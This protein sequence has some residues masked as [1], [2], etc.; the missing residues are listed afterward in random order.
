M[1]RRW[2]EAKVIAIEDMSQYTRKYYLKCE[3]EIFA[4]FKPGQFI[5]LDLPIHEKRTKRWKSY[6]IANLPTADDPIIELCIVYLEGGLA[7]E[8][9]FNKVK[10]G[11][12]L[13]FK[14]PAGVFTYP[15][16]NNLKMVMVCTGTGVA[17]FRSMLKY[18]N[19]LA[20]WP[21]DVHLIFG[22]RTE[23]GILYR[24]ELEELASVNERFTY[25]VAL[26]RADDWKGYRGYVHVVYEE[27]YPSPDED[28]LFYICGWTAMVDESRQRLVEKIGF[29]KQQ[30][31][32]ELYG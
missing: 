16:H 9:L 12:T 22:T 10:I 3:E 20:S 5:T 4:N 1:A 13:M 21:H 14:G 23:D 19:T 8:Y 28:V 11:D 24:E 6:S 15:E 2:H 32:F 26:S 27:Q 17:P 18:L 31:R 25:D 30:V 7:S 29:S